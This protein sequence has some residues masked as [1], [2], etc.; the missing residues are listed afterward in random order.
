MALITDVRSIKAAMTFTLTVVADC[1]ALFLFIINR[2]PSHQ[3][4]TNSRDG[5]GSGRISLVNGGVSK[6][7]HSP[8]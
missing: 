3:R 6:V 8:S 7:H 5:S 2:C 1:F 4:K